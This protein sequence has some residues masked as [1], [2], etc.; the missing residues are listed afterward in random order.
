MKIITKNHNDV[1][2]KPSPTEIQGRWSDHLFKDENTGEKVMFAKLDEGISYARMKV[3]GPTHF[4]IVKGELI[5][6]GQKYPAGTYIRIES[7]EEFTPQTSIGCE[8]LC[9]Y[10]KG[11]YR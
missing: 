5:I 7:E 11:Y 3:F 4:F 6:E 9:V 2:Y 10:T 8:V 1:D